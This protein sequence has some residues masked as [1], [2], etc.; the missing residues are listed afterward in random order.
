MI[1]DFNSNTDGHS[2]ARLP[3]DTPSAYWE[4]WAEIDQSLTEQ[5]TKYVIVRT[6]R[7]GKNGVLD[8]KYIVDRAASGLHFGAVI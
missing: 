8:A 7:T 2:L 1:D 3:K 6:F 5:S 4:N